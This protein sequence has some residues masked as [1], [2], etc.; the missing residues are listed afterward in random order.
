M[1]KE[2]KQKKVI[3]KK[4]SERKEAWFKIL[5]GIISGAV[6]YAWAYLIIVLT[7]INWIVVVFSGKRNKDIADFCEYWNTEAYKF[8]RYLTS[9]SNKRPFPFSSIEKM[10]KFE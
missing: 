1:V 6:L 8:V 5:V 9:V 7:V 4:M 2:A 3:K 10:S